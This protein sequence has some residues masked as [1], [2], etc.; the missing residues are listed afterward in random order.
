MSRPDAILTLASKTTG[1][2][3][4]LTIGGASGYDPLS[5]FD[6]KVLPA[7]P[8]DSSSVRASN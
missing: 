6:N 7:G 8:W 2:S 3:P 1:I 5:A 4:Q